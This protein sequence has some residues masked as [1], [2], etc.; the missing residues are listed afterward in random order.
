MNYILKNNQ[1]KNQSVTETILHNR[2]IEDINK[3]IHS[4]DADINDFLE[5][6]EDNLKAGARMLLSA[7]KKQK[8]TLIVVDCDC[9]GYTSAALLYNY[10]YDIGPLWVDNKV[11]YEMHSSK[12]HGLEDMMNIILTQN[13]EFVIC[14]DSSSNDYQEHEQLK[15]AGI[16]VLVLD[17]HLADKISENA[18][19]INNQLSSYP[20][21]EL[22]GV[23]ITWQFCR[24]I[25]SL[26]NKDYANKYLDLV[27]LGLVGDMMSL[28]EIE[29]KQ[30]IH[31]GFQETN[32]C[33]PF[34]EYMID[35]NSFSLN[36]DNYK[37]NIEGQACTPTGAAW[38]IVPF[39][40]AITRSGTLE[41]KNIVF[42]SMLNNKGLQKVP[43]TK[44]GHKEGEKEILAVQAVRLVSNVKNRQ[45]REE[46]KGLLLLN[47]KIEKDNMLE[48]KVLIFYLQPNEIPAEIRGLIANKLMAKYQRPCCILTLTNRGTYEGSLRGYT[49]TG[50]N[51]FRD[52]CEKFPNLLY[53][54]GHDNAAG[55]GIL[56]QDK[57]TFVDFLN[58]ELQNI[59]SEACYYVDYEYKDTD[60]E[61]ADTILEIA[62]LNDYWGQDLD[63]PYIVVKAQLTP[64]N[65]YIMKKNTL[66]I[67]LP[68]NIS[69]IKFNGTEKEIEDFSVSN[70]TTLVAICRCGV[71]KWNG[72]S[73]PQLFL[74]DYTL[75]KI[76]FSSNMF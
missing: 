67:S 24:Y 18:V 61:L 50:L 6:G 5:L 34:L 49:K 51:S 75:E 8:K 60:K 20:N 9:D 14:P 59:P 68:N 62:N 69:I 15:K 65:F 4:T 25:D 31:K 45:T 7:W 1:N 30:L 17:H 52:I 33:N 37:S 56:E 12:Q 57:D 55:L 3:Y 32:I 63:K 54:E 72:N 2:G 35:K 27:A 42:M 70:N 10:L 47:Q 38:F 53:C 28:R 19:I 66:K 64:S 46:E 26:I 43:S 71:N 73:Y 22:S 40:N 36:K 76:K 23:G 58:K 39:I 29:T 41:E 11:H 48:N 16:D 74:E 13:F 44:R 21:K